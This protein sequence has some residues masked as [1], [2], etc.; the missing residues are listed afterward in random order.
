MCERGAMMAAISYEQE[1]LEQIRDMN[2]A[3][4]KEVLAFARGLKRP[5]GESGKQFIE[6]TKDIHID[7]EDLAL[8]KAA[9]EEWCERADDFP[10]VNFDE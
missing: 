6:R 2:E 1:I 3:Q 4:Q 7:P 9:I 8:M 10:E 5:T